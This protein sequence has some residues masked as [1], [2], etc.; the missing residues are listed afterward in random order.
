MTIVVAM[1]AAIMPI[2]LAVITVM[3]TIVVAFARHSYD[4]RRR[5]RHY[6]HQKATP[7]NALSISH[8]CSVSYRAL[9]SNASHQRILSSTG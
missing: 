1:L 8:D 7:Q 3:I 5:K 9:E 6:R 4:T 2:M